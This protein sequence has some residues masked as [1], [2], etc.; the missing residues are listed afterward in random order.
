MGGDTSVSH[1]RIC[2]LGDLAVEGSFLKG[3]GI[4]GDPRSPNLEGQR[5]PPFC[6]WCSLDWFSS[7]NHLVCWAPAHL[8][9]SFQIHCVTLASLWEGDVVEY[10]EERWWVCVVSPPP[11]GFTSCLPLPLNLSTSC[12]GSLIRSDVSSL[13]SSNLGCVGSLG[14]W[15]GTE[16]KRGVMWV[17]ALANC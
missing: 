11:S 5:C 3:D 2:Q 14:F 7:R 6:P 16:S 15:G 13:L 12:Q 8:L 17:E 9:G 1:F 10:S 4:L